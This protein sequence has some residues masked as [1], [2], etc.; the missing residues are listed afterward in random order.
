MIQA[1]K[2]T[3][4]GKSGDKFPVIIHIG[5]ITHLYDKRTEIKKEQEMQS[6]AFVSTDDYYKKMFAEFLRNKEKFLKDKGGRELF[7]VGEIAD[8]M[9]VAVRRL[10]MHMSDEHFAVFKGVKINLSWII[11]EKQSGNCISL[12]NHAMWASAT[13]KECN[14]HLDKYRGKP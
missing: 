8:F 5:T 10:S 3:R 4:Q 6:A 12:K 7:S 9:G 13:V 2:I 14:A 11:S 1:L